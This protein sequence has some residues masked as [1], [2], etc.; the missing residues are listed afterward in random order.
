ML[1]RDGAAPPARDAAVLAVPAAALH[2]ASAQVAGQVPAVDGWLAAIDRAVAAV[3]GLPL[4]AAGATHDCWI[5]LRA[6]LVA[7]R[8]QLAELGNQLKRAAELLGGLDR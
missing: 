5:P 1:A 4:R 2:R 8:D 3:S 6:V 7:E